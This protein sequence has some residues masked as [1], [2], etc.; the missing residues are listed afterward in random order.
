MRHLPLLLCSVR[1]LVQKPIPDPS[2]LVVAPLA[3]LQGELAVRAAS[4]WQAGHGHASQETD[5]LRISFAVFM[6]QDY[7]VCQAKPHRV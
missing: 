7:C 2:A 1:A 6:K 4:G 5:F 3:G